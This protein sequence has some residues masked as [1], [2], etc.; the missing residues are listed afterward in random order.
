MSTVISDPTARRGG[1]PILYVLGAFPI[2]CFTGA[3][4]TDVA[5]VRTANILWAD[6][7]AWLLA[8]GMAAAVVAAVAGGLSLLIARRDRT[9]ARRPAWPVALGSLLVLAVALLDNFVHSRDGWTSVMPEGLALSAVTVLATLATAW[10][11][12]GAGR[13]R[14]AAPYS[15]ARL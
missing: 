9:R 5:Y 11:A 15:G 14:G 12:L 13:G 8:V 2:A 1:H 7:S 10:L 3:L 4:L 6:F